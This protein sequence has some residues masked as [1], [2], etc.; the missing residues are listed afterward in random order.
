MNPNFKITYCVGTYFFIYTDKNTAVNNTMLI[1][2][3]YIHIY[4]YLNKRLYTY[5]TGIISSTQ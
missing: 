5:I 4:T 2:K 3:T 1:L